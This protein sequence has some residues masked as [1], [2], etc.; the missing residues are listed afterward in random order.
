MG[1]M[2]QTYSTDCFNPARMFY[3]NPTVTQSALVFALFFIL[4][5]IFPKEGEFF[6]NRTKNHARYMKR[7]NWEEKK[8]E[9]YKTI[10]SLD[11]C[12]GFLCVVFAFSFNVVFD[13]KY[14]LW[15]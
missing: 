9:F 1:F 13:L 8:L 14:L 15:L 3:S 11:D 6:A 4:L 12:L 10:L 7:K 2:P 5:S